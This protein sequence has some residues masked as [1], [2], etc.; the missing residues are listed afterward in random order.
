MNDKEIKD[1][2][3]K[4]NAGT[5]SIY[6][7]LLEVRDGLNLA[8]LDTVDI[9]S[10]LSQAQTDI[11]D[12][13]IGVNLVRA[14]ATDLRNGLNQTQVDIES[15]KVVVIAIGQVIERIGKKK[16]TSLDL[17]RARFR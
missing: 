5:D 2:F 4:I 14:D 17:L 7:L 3:K 15:I 1:E 6:A 16:I 8:K 9:K 13:K 11:V 12:M 10:R